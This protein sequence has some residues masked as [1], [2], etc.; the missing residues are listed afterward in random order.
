MF[1]I[2]VGIIGL[3]IA[4]DSKQ[5]DHYP[6]FFVP[7]GLLLGVLNIGVGIVVILG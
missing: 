5:S 2:L 7:M 6:N 4:Y 1:N 3:Y